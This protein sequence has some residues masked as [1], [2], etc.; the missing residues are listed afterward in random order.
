MG[1]LS[2][3]RHLQSDQIEAVSRVAAR[4][5]QEDPLF[6]Y[7]Y[8][9]STERKSKAITKCKHLILLGIMSGEVHITSSNFEGVAVWAPY[10]IKDQKRDNQSKEII[11]RYRRTKREIF[12]EEK[13]QQNA[14]IFNS[15]HKEH[16][17]FPHWE[18]IMIAVDSLHQGNGYASMLLRPK[19]RELDKQNL[20][21]YVNIHNENNVALYEHFGFKLVGEI[22]VPNSNVISY[23]MLRNKK[24]SSESKSHFL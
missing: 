12:S 13:Y 22:R 3:L 18:L 4:A 19:L 6:K 10:G 8:P 11:R 7:Y 17:N 9:D 21:C 23:G 1:I 14:I 24:Q 16:A 2:Y 5:F 15:L 20:H